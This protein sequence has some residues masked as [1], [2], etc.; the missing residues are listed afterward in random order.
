MITVK[1][2]MTPNP[3][4]LSRFDSLHDARSLMEKHRFRHIPIVDDGQLVGLVTQRNIFAH[5]VSSQE[6]MSKDEL[7]EIETGTI[8][9]D[10]MSTNIISVTA[11]IDIADAAQLVFTK[12]IGCLPVID[13]ENRLIG[14]I[15]DHDFVSITIQL[16]DMMQQQEPLDIDYD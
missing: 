2:M 7:S 4:T 8:L 16:L 11:N 15:T 5:G 13:H 1:E 6:L 3:V 10:I 12:K 9:A 14:I